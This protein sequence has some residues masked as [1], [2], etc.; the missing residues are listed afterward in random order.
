MSRNYLIIVAVVILLA[1]AGFVIYSRGNSLT[2]LTPTPTT[3]ESTPAPEASSMEAP[4]KGEASDAAMKSGEAALTKPMTVT[5][6]EENN[7]AQSGTATLE[8]KNGKVV[9]TLSLT[10][11]SFTAAQPAHIHVGKCPDVGAVQYPLTSVVN[12]KSETTLDIDMKT[13]LSGLPLGVNVHKSAAEAKIYT[14]CGD[15]KT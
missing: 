4:S 6:A 1:V 7:S 11:G 8:E 14:A 9:V 15:I 5:L 12:G 10:G 3:S 2:S 13:L